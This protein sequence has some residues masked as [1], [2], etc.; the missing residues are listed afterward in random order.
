[1]KNHAQN[2]VEK[3][4]PDPFLINKNW[5]CL[6]INILKFHTV[7]F[8]LWQLEDHWN[9]LNLS[10]RP[11][12]FTTYKTFLKNKKWSGTSLPASFSAWFLKK[13]ISLVIF[14]YLTKF[15]R[16]TKFHQTS[17]P[18]LCEILSNMCIIIVCYVYCN[19][20]LTRL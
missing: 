3:L 16:L 13:H 8:N 15:H 10:C 14:Y 11:F 18:L 19:C 5:A 6:W 12:A 9:I 4:F 2:V 20:L 7:F 17:L 1:M